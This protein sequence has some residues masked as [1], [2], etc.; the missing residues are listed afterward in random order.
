MTAFKAYIAASFVAAIIAGAGFVYLAGKSHERER[1]DTQDARDKLETI[2]TVE[3]LE[4]EAENS[5]DDALADS[6]SDV[7]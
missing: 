4:D 1:R 2:T 5:S 7:Q 6:I 3:E